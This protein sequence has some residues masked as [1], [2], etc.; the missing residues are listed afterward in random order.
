[1]IKIILF[2]KMKKAS[3]KAMNR[4]FPINGSRVRKS[5]LKTPTKTKKALSD[6]KK[7][8]SI[9]FTYVS[10]LKAMGLLPRSNGKYEISA[11]YK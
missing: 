9:G 4:P 2:I 7:G 11:K 10:S 3:P 8:K 5:P 6:Y 1:M